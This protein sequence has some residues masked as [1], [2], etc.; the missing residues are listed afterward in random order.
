MPNRYLKYGSLLRHLLLN[1]YTVEGTFEG[2]TLKA[3]IADDGTTLDYIARLAFPGGAAISRK[4]LVTALKGPTLAD[5]TADLVVVGA[6]RLLIDQY[7][8]RGFRII[9]KWLQL[10]LPV[11]EEP[12]T[13]LD[14]FGRETRHYFKRMINKVNDN[15][16]ECEMV[17]DPSWFSRFYHEMYRPYI[18]HRFSDCAEVH[19]PHILE[20]YYRKGNILIAK[21]N[22]EPVAGIIV[23]RT[24]DILQMP[25]IGIAR[26]DAELMKEGVAFAM[27]Y[28][29]AQMAHSQ[30]CAY[31][32]FGLSRP[33]LSD[34]TLKYK[35]NWHMDV[36]PFDGIAGVFAVATPGCA[37]QALRFLEA[38]PHFYMAGDKCQ[39][40]DKQQTDD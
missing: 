8:R 19:E 13:R 28:F 3:L 23:Y 30:G 15:G 31:L 40:S 32:N 9:P 33:F 35:L 22:G 12:F 21:K 36:L 5:S 20:K 10:L 4:K 24:S 18:L 11:Q 16:F 34:G 25:F 1:V 39:R 29:A 38:N 14:S 2:N 26:G 17:T 27:H 7:V 6:N 37:P